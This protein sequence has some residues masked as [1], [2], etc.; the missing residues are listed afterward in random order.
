MNDWPIALRSLRFHWRI[1]LAVVLA[2]AATTAVLTG[3]LIIGDSMR[4]SLRAITFDRLGKVDVLISGSGFF[5]EALAKELIQS[6]A[7]SDHF[8]QAA[9]ILFFPN[10]TA[11]QR[12]GQTFRNAGD[13]TVL[14][15][16]SDFWDLGDS[17]V[18]PR[19]E[20]QGD[21]AVINQVLADD[22][23]IS[24]ADVQA[25]TA[26]ITVGVPKQKML[27][28]D[29]ALGDKQDLVV[30]LVNLQVVDVVPAKSLGRF[31][32]HPTQIPTRN[33]YLPIEPLQNALAD[34]VLKY[35]ESLRQAN[36]I[37]IAGKSPQIPPSAEHV[38][39]LSE[40]LVPSLG[41]VGMRVK[42]V[43]QSFE[44]EVV[45]D[46]FSLSSDRLM[47][48]EQGTQSIRS[49]FP[50]AC[51]LLTYLANDISKR[52]TD[53][54]AASASGIPF[55][56]I[57]AASFGAGLPLVS[58]DGATAPPLA[59]GEIALNEWAAKDL[60]AQVGD[61]IRIK[62]FEPETTH[63]DEIER[64]AD[65]RVASVL[66][67]TEPSKPFQVRRRG[68]II[69]AEF[70]QRPTMANDPDMTPEVPGLT[71]AESIDRWDLPFETASSIRSQDDTYWSDFRM[72]PKAFV[73][74]KT[75][76]GLW[77]S[78]F[79][80]V[81]SFRIPVAGNS[82]E[83][84]AKKLLNQFR[85]DGHLL[86][87]Q[88]IPIKRQGLAA[89]SGATPFDALFM[90][91]SLFVIASA[92]LL[93][94]LLFRL[95]IQQRSDELGTL[96]AS[97]FRPQRVGRLWMKEM[98]GVCLL[99]ALL[100][101]AVGIGY[102]MLMLWGLK[103]WW[104]GAITTPFLEIHLGRWT[105]PLGL[106]CGLTTCFLTIGW[107]VR[108]I[109][110]HS[111]RA[112]LNHQI[113]QPGWSANDGSEMRSSTRVK[114]L[115]FGGLGL[116]ATLS[117]LATQLGGESQ[118]G[119]LLTAGF[120]VLVVAL[121]VVW[122]WLRSSQVSSVSTSQAGQPFS[123]NLHKL[124][125]TNAGRTP[126]RSTLTIALVAVASFLIIAISAF[127]QAPS[128]RGTAGFEWIARTSQP[129]FADLNTAQGQRDV[130]LGE[131]EQLSATSSVL[132]FRYKSGEDAS[133]NNP[134]QTSQ[135]QVL[136]VP[137]KTADYFSDEQ[138]DRFSFTMTPGDHPWELLWQ[139]TDDGSIPVF[140]DKNTAWYS[141]KVYIPGSRF[142]V[143]YDS[144]ETLTF[145]LVGLLDNSIL[146]GR[147]LMSEEQ[148]TKAFPDVS[149]YRYFLLKANEEDIQALATS[150]ADQGFDARSAE[151][152][153]ASF[154][155][156]QNT[157][158]STFQSLGA[159]GL[160]LG[161]FGLAA[162]QL[163]GIVE[164]RRELAVMRAMGFSKPKIAK[165]VLLENAFLLICGLLIGI[166][167]ALVTTIP[168]YFMGAASVPWR[169][170]I[171]IF[172][173]ITVVGLLT[174]WLASRSIFRSP[175]VPAL[176]N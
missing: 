41:D 25:G 96:L 145:Q 31:G 91:L 151:S 90:G 78:R 103:T 154:M 162:V 61:S 128:Q 160:L 47:I 161:T 144:G 48:P 157:Y 174:S 28:G 104:V 45:F 139:E 120:C 72:T 68:N 52:A 59:D 50:E 57:T 88:V 166:V 43:T 118:A 124:A 176:R 123:L 14:G 39:A 150:L 143:T 27:P 30:R 171:A 53:D 23:N 4:G 7:F 29:S 102:A 62:Y 140:L 152:V 77:G 149:G 64:F 159:L 13:V 8:S 37:L 138:T 175:L 89:S 42:R 136:G 113:E 155:A 80:Q 67:L 98:L 11:E 15:I 3:A 127:Q 56:T 17:S 129:V 63:G 33:V 153:L 101:I 73:A 55:S 24:M 172:G 26:R 111:I 130:L 10:G 85:S 117:V 46:Y 40:S 141:L 36:M 167:S 54:T 110:Q 173:V 69:P 1:H 9:P 94:S 156:V 116:A 74:L 5:R 133:C 20:M 142:Q 71:D 83:S 58:I 86:G 95:G 87:M 38:T 2:V 18:R 169:E 147:V 121:T 75:G 163:R 125:W 137:R 22:L 92:L 93:V 114:L 164:R 126:L 44:D 51:E 165:L 82:T 60:Q 112:L 100:G 16:R 109:R 21:V 122:H 65:F 106:L 84:I 79:G 115:V 34:G 108:S 148:F 146:Q 168:H 66:K 19:T 49:A 81:T 170:L 32:I 70:E 99:G 105:L 97:G 6:P 135:P 35:K 158:L 76:Q 132:S 12:Q 107:S 131:R 119:A 134:Y